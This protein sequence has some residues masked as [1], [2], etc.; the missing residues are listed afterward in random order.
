MALSDHSEI[1]NLP[2]GKEL[3]NIMFKDSV[4]FNVALGCVITSKKLIVIK[5]NKSHTCKHRETEYDLSYSVFRT[6]IIWH[7]EEWAA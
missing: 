4:F 5:S 3:H 1:M 2:Y 7:A 6:I